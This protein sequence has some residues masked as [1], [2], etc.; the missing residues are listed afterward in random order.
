MML[1]IAGVV[2]VP[3]TVEAGWW[4]LLQGPQACVVQGVAAAVGNE[5]I[6]SFAATIGDLI[7]R[8]SAWFMSIAAIIFNI[9]IILTMN[10]KAIYQATP[11]IEQM[12]VVIRNISSI[13]IIFMLLYTSIR[14][15]LGI[16]DANIKKLVGNIIIAGLLINFSLFFTRIAID[17]SNLI[18]LQFYRAITPSSQSTIFNSSDITKILDRSYL[19]GGISNVLMSGLQITKIYDPQTQKSLLR[20]DVQGSEFFKIFVASAAGSGLMVMAGLSF[21]GAGIIFILRL[22]ILILLMGFAPIYFIGIVF[23]EIKSKISDKWFEWLKQQLIVLPVYL[24]FMYVALQFISTINGVAGQEGFF[25][26][27]GKAQAGSNEVDSGIFLSNVG[28]ILQYTIAF[29]LINIPLYVAVQTGGVSAKWGNGARKW[30]S[31][32]LKGGASF[33]GRNTYGAMASKVADSN[34][35]KDAASKN[36]I[37]AGALRGMRGVAG[38]YDS[39]EAKKA[40]ARA[41]FGESLGYNKTHVDYLDNSIRNMKNSISDQD[42]IINNPAST[43]ADIDMAKNQKKTYQ[44]AIRRAEN[45][46]SE[47][48][49]TRQI[50]YAQR[51]DP[52]DID[53]ATGKLRPMS[54]MQKIRKVGYVAKNEEMG[55]SQIHIKNIEAE[56]EQ[57]KKL[58]DDK[59]KEQDTIKGDI[60]KIDERERQNRMT[61]LESAKRDDLKRDLYRLLDG[62]IDPVTGLR[63]DGITQI[64]KD[65]TDRELEIKRYKNIS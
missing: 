45:A 37:M 56:V 60:K 27:L 59:K 19:D 3:N 43:R 44:Q 9:S 55:S 63:V 31:S 8:T 32:K 18:S 58:L 23:P 52:R 5:I 49:R 54:L 50:A 20:Q 22:V 64:N 62:E 61:G 33:A 1:T 14:T 16:G 10:I 28:L 15:I 4:C 39:T 34:F 7:L 40:E 29:I 24:L 12:W 11:A 47:Q 13:F 46:I 42:L 6:D 65:I 41:K 21:F 48:K 2:F 25:A 26:A 51:L 17:A 53:P 35:M 57:L 30:A 38:S 36:I